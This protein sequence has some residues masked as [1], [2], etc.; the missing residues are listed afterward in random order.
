MYNEGFIPLET[1]QY[2]IQLGD[3][4]RE[5]AEQN[6]TS[7]DYIISINPHIVPSSLEVGQKVI[8][9]KKINFAS[10]PKGTMPYIVQEGDTLCQI[11]IKFNVSISQI[12]K[13][14]PTL[15]PYS[16]FVGQRI[17]IP[18][19]WEAYSNKDYNVSFM[20]P[21]L[22]ENTKLQRHEGRDGFF[23]VAAIRSRK[24]LRNVCRYEAF[25]TKRSYGTNPK[26]INLSIEK[27]SA[28]L[29]YPSNDQPSS[30]Q[31]ISALLVEY[32]QNIE[33]DNK[34]YNYLILWASKYYIRQIGS[35]L[36]FLKY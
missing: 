32:P 8:L 13:S 14:N 21:A 36:S 20:Y 29:I 11:A 10:C 27:Q 1:K 2:T 24:P 3:T 30:N 22:W 35:T 15:N 16:L 5:L 33:I 7:V 34:S 6:G 4:L 9:P 19:T 18:K 25:N 17:C 23:Q 26:F 28:S 31:D 12:M